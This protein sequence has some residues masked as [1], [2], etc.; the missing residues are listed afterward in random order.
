MLM[1]DA[2]LERMGFEEHLG[3]IQ[4]KHLIILSLIS[5]SS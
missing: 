5:Q 4:Q 1:K 2:L 3:L